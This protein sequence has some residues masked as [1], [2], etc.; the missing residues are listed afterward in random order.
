ME[1][2]K[3]K[4]GNFRSHSIFKIPHSSK[5]FTLIE[6]LLYVVIFSVLS[7]SFFYF[8]QSIGE[9]RVKQQTIAEVEQQGLAAMQTVIQT[10]RN[11]ENITS[12]S[13]GASA[14]SVTLDVITVADDPTVFD[15]SGGVLRITKGTSAA[16]SL[17]NSRV[18]ASSL[19]IQNLSRPSTPGIIRVQF[20]LTAVNSTGRSEYLYAKTFITSAALRK[21]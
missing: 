14:S 2:R 18:T 17:T 13:M 8:M 7:L 10:A 15:L 21:P 3:K 20:T 11:A 1:C 4:W 5:G 19:T 9:A 12:P 16:V 6:L